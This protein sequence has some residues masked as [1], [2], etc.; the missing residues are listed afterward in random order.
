[1]LAPHSKKGSKKQK[2]TETNV[3]FAVIQKKNEEEWPSSISG[4]YFHRNGKFTV[5]CISLLYNNG[6]QSEVR[7]PV[8][9]GLKRGS[10]Q[11]CT[12][13]P[14]A[15]FAATNYNTHYRSLLINV[16]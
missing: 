3:F 2:T 1:V 9:S 4:K 12:T 13:L 7:L 8:E 10:P 14:S 5:W 15:L 6:F 11:E 16:Q